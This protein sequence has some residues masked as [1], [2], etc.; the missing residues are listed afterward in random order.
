M[1][2]FNCNSCGEQVHTSRLP[3]NVCEKCED[4]IKFPKHYNSSSIQ[5]IDA[6]EAWKLDFRLANAVKY[7]ARAGKK[8]PNKLK[9]DLE[10]AVWYIQRYIDKECTNDKK[11]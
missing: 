7:L 3:V 2:F 11:D 1:G 8:D 6:I 10:K 9:E 5:P 4:I